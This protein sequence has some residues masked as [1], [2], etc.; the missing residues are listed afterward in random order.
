MRQNNI[1]KN[2]IFH[3]FCLLFLLSS[4]LFSDDWMA[5]LIRYGWANGSGSPND[6]VGK[7]PLNPNIHSYRCDETDRNILLLM[8]V[9]PISQAVN[10]RLAKCKNSVQR[11]INTCALQSNVQ[12]TLHCKQCDLMPCSVLTFRFT[13]C[14]QICIAQDSTAM[15]AISTTNFNF[16]CR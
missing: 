14:N 9:Q 5:K 11:A 2:R 10:S 15:H 4:F 3:Q 1:T 8:R 6:T 16:W 13:L 12:S 7:I